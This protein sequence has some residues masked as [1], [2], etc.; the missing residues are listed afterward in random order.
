MLPFEKSI[1]FGFKL[2]FRDV[3]FMNLRF[4]I[5]VFL[6]WFFD[7]IVI[8]SL[9]I[10]GTLVVLVGSFLALVEW[11]VFM[12]EWFFGVE[13]LFIFEQILLPRGSYELQ[14]VLAPLDGVDDLVN[15]LAV[16]VQVHLFVV[17]YWDE[18]LAFF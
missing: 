5:G 15:G 9:Q 3:F 13:F 14:R 6:V 1:D 4:D 17:I 10:V 12:D 16:V 18:N 8:V 2:I 7:I 11:F